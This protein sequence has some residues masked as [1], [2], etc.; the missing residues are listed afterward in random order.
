MLNFQRFNEFEL[1]SIVWAKNKLNRFVL[2]IWVCIQMKLQSGVS[3]MI[4]ML[5]DRFYQ[6]DIEVFVKIIAWLFI[7]CENEALMDKEFHV[8]SKHF[9]KAQ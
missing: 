6:Q 2:R 9:L 8:E 5:F 1:F 7:Q 3:G 4:D